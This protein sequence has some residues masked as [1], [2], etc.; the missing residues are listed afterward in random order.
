MMRDRLAALLRPAVLALLGAALLACAPADDGGL[1]ASRLP[2]EAHATLALLDAG[3]PFPYRQDGTTFH[4]REGLL[5]AQ[6]RGYYREYTVDTPGAR[7]RGAR[8]IVTGG[9]P[10]EVYYWTADHYRS[11][12]RIDRKR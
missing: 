3:G 11:F 5:P 9:R 7:N 2:A 12:Q 1:A 8:R 10:P 6:P 4:N